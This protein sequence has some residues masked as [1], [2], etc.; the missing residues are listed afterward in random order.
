LRLAEIKRPE[1]ASNEV[2]VQ[3][4]AAGGVDRGTWHLMMGVPYL[5]RVLG[6]GFRRPKNPVP[7]RDVAGTVVEVGSAVY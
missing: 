6:F 3:V 4:R 7:G 2:L 5:L 1:I